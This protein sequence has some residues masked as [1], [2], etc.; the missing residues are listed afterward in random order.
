ME[1]LKSWKLHVEMEYGI[2]NDVYLHHMFSVI[3]CKNH[4]PFLCYKDYYQLDYH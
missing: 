2:Y 3:H 4:Q 1:V